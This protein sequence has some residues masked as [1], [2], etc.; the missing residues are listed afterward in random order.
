MPAD[1]GFLVRDA[2][3]LKEG[4]LFGDAGGEEED[5]LAEE[6]LRLRVKVLRLLAVE[7]IE[8]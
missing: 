6:R 4:D 5:D 7:T 8:S 1:G 3:S 2:C